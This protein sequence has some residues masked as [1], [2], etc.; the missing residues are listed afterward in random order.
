MPFLEF[1]IVSGG[2]AGGYA[3][4]SRLRQAMHEEP[5]KSSDAHSRAVDSHGPHHSGQTNYL[6]SLHGGLTCTIMLV[7]EP[8]VGKSLFLARITAPDGNTGRH[9]LPKTMAPAWQQADVLLPS[10]GARQGRVSTAAAATLSAGRATFQVLDTP[11]C[12]PELCVPFYRGVQCVVLMFDVGQ[13]SSFAKLKSDWFAAVT[14]HRLDARGNRHPRETTVVLAHVVDE[15]RNREVTRREAAAWCSSVGLPFFET[16]PAELQP[17]VLGHLA[18]VVAQP[19][20][21]DPPNAG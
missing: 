21:V 6:A 12:L 1:A 11:G 20:Q 17:K 18:R 5:A 9:A 15:R 10:Q 4:G 14:L 19:P 13:A 2:L 16:H 7:G 3:I 8:S